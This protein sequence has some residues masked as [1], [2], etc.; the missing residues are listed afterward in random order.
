MLDFPIT[1]AP[2]MHRRIFLLLAAFAILLSAAAARAQQPAPAQAPTEEPAPPPDPVKSMLGTWE[3]S[4]ADRDRRCN[5][6]LKEEPAAVGLKLEF[7]QACAGVFPFL[8]DV[9]GWNIKANDFLRFLNAA[10]KTVLDFSELESG[11]FETL[12]QGEGVLFLQTAAAVG[13]PPKAAADMV[14][15]WAIVRGDRPICALTLSGTSLGPEALALAIKQGCDVFVTRFAPVSWHMDRG[16][17]VL[18]STRGDTWRFEE[19][20]AKSW[21]RVPARADGMQMV[22]Q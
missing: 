15:E 2:V 12:R 21:Q 14:G 11:L 18:T 6:V 3:F 22:R 10:G 19:G 16:E 7:D 8:K 5:V 20:D 4:N 1:G 13:P 9:V 17:L